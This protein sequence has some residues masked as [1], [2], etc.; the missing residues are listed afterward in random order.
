MRPKK[1][2]SPMPPR[3]KAGFLS[4]VSSLRIARIMTGPPAS[5][6]ECVCGRPLSPESSPVMRRKTSSRLASSGRRA[7]SVMPASAAARLTSAA[8]EAGALTRTSSSCAVAFQP[9][10]ARSSA[11]TADVAGIL[12]DGL[13]AL[14]RLG[15]QVDQRPREQQLAVADHGQ[16][17]AGRLDLAEQVRRDDDRASLDR[18][19]REAARGSRRCRPG[20]DRWWA[21]RARAAR[22]RGAAPRRCRAAASCPARSASPAP[23]CAHAARPSPAPRPRA[24]WRCRA[25]APRSAG[26]C[27]PRGTGRRRGS[28]SARRCATRRRADARWANRRPGR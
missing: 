7:L 14:A 24:R 19:V 3:M 1:T 2:I 5:A 23:C 16:R 11:E 25:G 9:F 28:R 27:A 15:D 12:R 13:D 17:V 22:D 20:R 10:D 21:R 8:C 18:R 4:R 26:W 6:F